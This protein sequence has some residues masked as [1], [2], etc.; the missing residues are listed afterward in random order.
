M[1]R[2]Q[3]PT[4]GVRGVPRVTKGQPRLPL[5]T[6]NLQG[7]PDEDDS[8][9]NCRRG[10]GRCGCFVA[11]CVQSP[12]RRRHGQC[13]AGRQ[14]VGQRNGIRR[15]ELQRFNCGQH[16]IFRRHE[17]HGLDGNERFF[18]FLRFGQLAK[19]E[20][21]H[22]RHRDPHALMPTRAVVLGLAAFLALGLV[23]CQRGADT[24]A[25]ANPNAPGRPGTGNAPV[26]AQPAAPDSAGAGG[27][28]GEKGS[29]PH[30]GSSGGDAVPGTTGGGGSSA[31]PGT[32]LQGGLGAS[33]PGQ[34]SP[35]GEGSTNRTTRG[36]VGNR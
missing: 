2:Q 8:H 17:L 10:V 36:S 5:E 15:H 9:Q 32:G 29:L 12:G 25:T 14:S 33:G 1:H 20:Q 13:G 18:Q 7:V 16:G 6:H 22:R 28:S 19:S 31:P 3:L 27:S 34:S 35:A 23:A 30:P 4:R 24:G 11:Q 26:I 21:L